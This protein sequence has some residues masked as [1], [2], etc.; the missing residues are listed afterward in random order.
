MRGYKEDS[1]TLKGSVLILQKYSFIVDI[2]KGDGSL[3]GETKD[4]NTC[5]EEKQIFLAKHMSLTEEI[6]TLIKEES[7]ARIIQPLKQNIVFDF[8]NQ[9]I[10]N[11]NINKNI[12]KDVLNIKKDVLNVKKGINNGNIKNADIITMSFIENIVE[13]PANSSILKG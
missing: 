5:V 4:I 9:S 10:A 1:I 13:N 6:N 2:K 11:C 3:L 8:L 12:K 7:K